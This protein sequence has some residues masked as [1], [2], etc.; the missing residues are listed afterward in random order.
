MAFAP[1]HP[2]SDPSS[3][4]VSKGERPFLVIFQI[5][6]KI[7]HL[8]MRLEKV[9]QISLTQWA[10]LQELVNHPGVSPCTLAEVVG[11][12]PGTLTPLLVRLAKKE[13]V[14]VSK[15]PKDSR[16]KFI[17]LTRRG[18][19]TIDRADAH[20]I[21]WRDQLGVSREHLLRFR[22]SLDGLK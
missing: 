10:I 7:Q 19:E 2:V 13:L 22:D 12:Q 18:K 20:V 16:K 9:A 17:F 3:K 11:I 14:F 15:D 8:S 21:E 1:S 4:T 5:G 6:L